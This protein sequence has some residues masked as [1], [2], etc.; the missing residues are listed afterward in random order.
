MSQAESG[1]LSQAVVEL[2][3][4]VKKAQLEM[5]TQQ[6]HKSGPSGEAFGSV[7]ATHEAKAV[8]GAPHA[9][10]TARATS[11]I[12]QARQNSVAPLRTQVGVAE[13]EK[14]SALGRMLQDLINGQD[15]MTE[16]MNEC[17]SGHQYSPPDLLRVQA[18]VYRY[19]QELDL[20]TK[21]VD[22]ASGAVKQTFNTQV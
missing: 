8:N 4:E 12:L 16:I 17:L 1:G 22:K 3:Q 10:D 9:T 19:S 13:K 20:T 2:L 11:I 15:K 5:E 7:L 6:A 18:A 21:V 14:E